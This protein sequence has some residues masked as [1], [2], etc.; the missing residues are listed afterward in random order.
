MLVRLRAL[1]FAD[2]INEAES[3]RQQSMQF[4]SAKRHVRSTILNV[5]ERVQK[6][7]SLDNA[8]MHF[9]LKADLV[10]HLWAFRDTR[11]RAEVNI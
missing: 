3:E 10:E 11:D 6:I 4:R 2:D 7:V 5:A 9:A 8:D 1:Q